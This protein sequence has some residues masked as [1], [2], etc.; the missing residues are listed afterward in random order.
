[1][2]HPD[3]YLQM[4][5]TESQEKI[6]AQTAGG[7]KKKPINEEELLK[8]DCVELKRGED[9]MVNFIDVQDRFKPI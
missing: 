6:R 3:D 2:K 4:M 8:H 5:L 1:M 7:N 9:V